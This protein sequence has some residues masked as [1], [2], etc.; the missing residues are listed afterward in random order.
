MLLLSSPSGEL[1]MLTIFFNYI[2][3]GICIDRHVCIDHKF[4]EHHLQVVRRYSLA[5]VIKCWLIVWL[6]HVQQG[7]S[8]TVNFGIVSLF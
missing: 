8:N 6:S 4:T 3:I 2:C 5:I 7:L 1:D